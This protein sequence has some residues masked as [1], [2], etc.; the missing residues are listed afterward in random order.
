MEDRAPRGRAPARRTSRRRPPVAEPSPLPKQRLY[1]KRTRQWL[2]LAGIAQAIRL[3]RAEL[4]M[5]RKALARA[6]HVSE[7]FLAEVESGVGNISVTRLADVAEAL[8]QSPAAFLATVPSAG[9]TQRAQERG[10]VA[11]LG[12]RGAGKSSVG[13]RLARRMG[14]PFVELDQLV[15]RDAG[16]SLATIFEVY[17]ERHFRKLERETLLRFFDT[18]KAAVLATSGS[19]V[20]DAS[21]FDLLRKRSTTVWLK[22]RAKDH[23]E[24]VVAQGDGRPMRGRKNAMSELEALLGARAPLYA[25][26]AHVVDTSAASLEEAVERAA[27]AVGA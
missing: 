4:G 25:R 8:G 21:T 6:A 10:V 16:M 23:W 19:I 22:A 5:T 1:P 17:G 27:M 2:L 15:A 20:S 14:V 18:T 24:R 3:R 26:A 9:E 11:L 13:E 12:L 7:R